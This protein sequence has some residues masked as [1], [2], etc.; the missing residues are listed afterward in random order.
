MR[1]SL[2]NL[3]DET[4]N[5]LT[6]ISWL[7]TRFAVTVIAHVTMNMYRLMINKMV[8]PLSLDFQIA[9]TSCGKVN[10]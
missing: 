1:L 3:I 2:G 4:N 9:E 7:I 10:R 8:V 6:F 5:L